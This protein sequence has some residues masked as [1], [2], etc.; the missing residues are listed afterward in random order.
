[1]KEPKKIKINTEI[2]KILKDFCLRKN[3]NIAEFVEEA[4]LE[5]IEKDELQERVSEIIDNDEFN[6]EI[7]KEYLL[8]DFEA[9][10]KKH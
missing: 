3:K 4:I 10:K 7:L 5:K 8:D 2:E 6:E 9:Y 1:M